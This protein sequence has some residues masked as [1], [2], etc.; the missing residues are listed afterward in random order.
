M[1]NFEKGKHEKKNNSGNEQSEKDNLGKGRSE[2]GQ[3]VKRKNLNKDNSEQ[4]RCF[5]KARI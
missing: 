4:Q 3:L 1:D 5:W 2:E